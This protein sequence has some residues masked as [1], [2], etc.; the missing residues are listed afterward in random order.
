MVWTKTD[1]DVVGIDE[2]GSAA[3]TFRLT[4]NNVARWEDRGRMVSACWDF[5]DPIDIAS[6][7]N[8]RRYIIPEIRMLPG[9][10]VLKL[11]LRYQVTHVEGVNVRWRVLN[12]P[13]VTPSP[14]VLLT[15]LTPANHDVILNVSE[16]VRS[17]NADS[18]VLALEIESQAAV[19]ES[20]I[21]LAIA[22]VS[23]WFIATNQSPAGP[24]SVGGLTD[25][26]E[27]CSVTLVNSGKSIGL[28]SN[29]MPGGPY[30]TISNGLGTAAAAGT[31][32]GFWTW[33]KL[34]GLNSNLVPS[35]TGYFSIFNEEWNRINL[36]IYARL[37]F[38]TVGIQQIRTPT[39][40]VPG[41]SNRKPIIETGLETKN[42]LRPDYP[43]R[44]STHRPLYLEGQRQFETHTTVHSIGPYSGTTGLDFFFPS[45]TNL[46][47]GT[48]PCYPN[49]TWTVPDVAGKQ[50]FGVRVGQD[51]EFKEE[52]SAT[53]KVRRSMTIDVSMIFIGGFTGV[54]QFV[55]EAKTYTAGSGALVYQAPSVPFSVRPLDP[56]LVPWSGDRWEQLLAISLAHPLAMDF[57]APLPTNRHRRNNLIGLWDE[58]VP[59]DILKRHIVRRTVE[60]FDPDPAN[61]DP[62]VLIMEV[63][64]STTG[65]LVLGDQLPIIGNVRCFAMGW[66]VMGK[67]GGTPTTTGV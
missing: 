64:P 25:R 29:E 50:L 26:I 4:D 51:P 46:R 65:T 39:F 56:L 48:W 49:V 21:T 1:S 9:F 13:N 37:Q 58:E 3:V 16:W 14:V 30:Q 7:G 8:F 28:P 45:P 23:D 36:Q 17:A 2:P 33:P 32:A 15:S 44:A 59:W 61:A 18:L 63:R 41:R 31:D 10:T 19:S 60:V 57:S 22:G 55:L 54:H 53:V 62:E 67:Q 52:G 34:S 35:T 43:G 6:V 12:A 40:P 66:H 38:W 20:V 27:C 11:R 5:R 24:P 42:A 47:N